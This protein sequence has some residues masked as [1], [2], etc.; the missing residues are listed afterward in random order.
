MIDI[1]SINTIFYICKGLLTKGFIRSAI[2][3]CHLS[4]SN[5]ENFDDYLMLQSI[6]MSISLKVKTVSI[7]LTSNTI[8]DF[9]FVS[10]LTI[11]FISKLKIFLYREYRHNS[12]C[13]I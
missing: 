10:F 1:F 8:T 11:S 12:C 6:E 4:L 3:M 5:S 13:I 7:F 9:Y 2:I